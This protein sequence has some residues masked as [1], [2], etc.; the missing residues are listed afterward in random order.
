MLAT[1]SHPLTTNERW[2]FTMADTIVTEKPC[3][4]CGELYPETTQY[5]K[6]DKR[7]K[8]GIAAQCRNC[9]RT[10][11]HKPDAK[12]R[13][14][15]RK[16]TPEYK[17]KE[18]ERRHSPEY[19]ARERELAKDPE[20]KAKRAARHQKWLQKP[21]VKAKI[22]AHNRSPE[23]RE[24]SRQYQRVNRQD[25]AYKQ[26]EREYRQRPETRELYRSHTQQRRA[27]QRGLAATLTIED[28]RRAIDYFNGCCP[29]CGRQFVDLFDTHTVSFDHWWIPQSKNGGLTPDNIIPLCYG[30]DGCNNSK[31]ARDPV[32]WLEWKLGKRK[33]KEVLKR[34]Q[35]FFDWLKTQ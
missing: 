33:A 18:K 13:D 15:A 10:Y 23:K 4:K 21:D 17:A 5:F 3:S 1:L 2:A 27:Q 35:A 11:Y 8:N 24:W 25:P 6:P 9:A 20:R 7:N 34:I 12:L 22:E 32:E 31:A 16:Q 29:V 26:R 14:K 19:R 30:K 28:K